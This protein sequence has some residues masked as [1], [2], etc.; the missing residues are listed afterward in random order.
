MISTF[1]RGGKRSSDVKRV[2]VENRHC[3][4]HHQSPTNP[5]PRQG[6]QRV[7]FRVETCCGNDSGSTAHYSLLLHQT[8]TF[9]K[10]VG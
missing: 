10:H 7:R 4:R 6:N 1:A 9:Q 5:P 2:E 3:T 8:G